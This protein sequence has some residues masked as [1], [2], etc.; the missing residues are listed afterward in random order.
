[1]RIP[2]VPLAAAELAGVAYGIAARLGFES[3]RAPFGFGAMTFAFVVLVPLAI[4][5]LTVALAP[6]GAE[7]PSRAVSLPLVT[8]VACLGF[9]LAMGLEGIICVILI[10][11]L[12]LLF[13]ALG[14]LLGGGL[15]RIA[16]S[17]RMYASGIATVLLLPY[18][19]APLEGRLPLPD[20]R[21]VVDTRVVIHAD[22]E[23]VW[24]NV[25]R[26]TG[27]RED[28]NQVRLAHR[29]GFPR[30]ITATLSKEGLGG[31]RYAIFERGVMLRETVTAW[32]PGRRMAFTIDPASIPAGALDE[33]VTVGGPFFDVI[34]GSYEIVPL[35][36]G[37]V[38]LRL[39]TT[40][41]LSTHFNLYAGFWTDLLM[42]QIQENLLHVVRTRAEAGR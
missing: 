34:D 14:G 35:G 6:K 10:A 40:H 41:R 11:P 29:I 17:R 5:F 42:R 18:A 13:A 28:E 24:R 7:R 36:G 3:D 2:I 4:G 19:A 30:P 32:L 25:V 22:A 1:M 27:I 23:T 21:R 37:R 31:S 15:R 12:F 20:T 9:V 38:E 33:H 39:R 8:V 16:R 26:P